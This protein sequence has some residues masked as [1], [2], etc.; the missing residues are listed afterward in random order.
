MRVATLTA[1]LLLTSIATSLSAQTGQGRLI[2]IVV[3]AQR[4]VLPGVIV[5]ATS[6]ALIGQQTAVTQSDGHYVF[7][8]LPPGIYALTFRLPNF[9][10]LVREGIALPLAITITVDAQL[11]LAAVRESVVVAGASPVVDA[12]TTKV[13]LNM[14]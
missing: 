4:A 1:F 7:P 8:A 10:T 5:A 9:E 12:S 3:D 14:R 11:S 13:G 6:P 2:G